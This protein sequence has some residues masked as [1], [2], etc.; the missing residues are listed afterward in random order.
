[1]YTEIGL[2]AE[3]SKPFSFCVPTYLALIQPV[4]SLSVQVRAAKELF[5]T[6]H[7]LKRFQNKLISNTAPKHQRS[8]Y[9]AGST[10]EGIAIKWQIKS[11]IENIIFLKLRK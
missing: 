11:Q 7:A 2:A 6:L 4:L 1:M 3:V 5:T 10:G 9:T 8:E